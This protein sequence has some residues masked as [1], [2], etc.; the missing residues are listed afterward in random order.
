MK[1][2]AG[3]VYLLSQPIWLKMKNAMKYR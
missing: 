3:I 1:I 2:T